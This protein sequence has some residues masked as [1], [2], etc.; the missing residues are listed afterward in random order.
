M[1]YKLLTETI[2]VVMIYKLR[3]E[4][5]RYKTQITHRNKSL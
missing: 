4:K 5:S 1:K 3:I 2:Y